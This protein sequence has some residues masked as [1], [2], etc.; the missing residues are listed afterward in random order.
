MK[1]IRAGEPVVT[2]TN[3]GS[4]NHVISEPLVETVSATTRARRRRSRSIVP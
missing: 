4:A 2:S 1:P 3:H